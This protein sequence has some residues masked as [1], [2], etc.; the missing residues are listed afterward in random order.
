MPSIILG[1][2]VTTVTI[3][4]FSQE[5]VIKRNYINDT[6]PNADVCVQYDTT[7]IVIDRCVF[8]FL[9]P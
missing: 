5:N 3:S 9:N 8:A 2:N 7:A 1:V 4:I 6:A